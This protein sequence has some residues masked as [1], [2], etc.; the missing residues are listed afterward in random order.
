MKKSLKILAV[1]TIL[2]ISTSTN[3]VFSQPHPSSQ[4]NGSNTGGA[5]I[6]GQSAP[7]GSGQLILLTLGAIY[8][9]KK[10]FTIRQDILTKRQTQQY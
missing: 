7:V 3:A 5:P 1:I 6:S 9:S 4:A 8:A 10:A 2:S